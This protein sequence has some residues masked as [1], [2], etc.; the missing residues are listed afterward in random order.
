MYGK[1]LLPNDDNGIV[2]DGNVPEE[3]LCPWALNLSAGR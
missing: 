3:M 2:S 1:S